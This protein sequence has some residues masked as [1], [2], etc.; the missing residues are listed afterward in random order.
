M[1]QSPSS[2]AN[3]HSS[4]QGSPRLLWDAK[5]HYR[6][7]KS[8]SLIP[9]MSQMNLIHIFSS[10]FPRIHTNI[11]LASTPMSSE[12]FSFLPCVLLRKYMK[13]LLLVQTFRKYI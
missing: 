3:S 1:G 4:S 11:I 5:I 2:E 9:T 6:V 7:Q 10:S 12:C 13:Q 8:P